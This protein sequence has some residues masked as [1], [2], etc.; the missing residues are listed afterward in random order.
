MSSTF[1]LEEILL[2]LKKTYE[3]ADKNIR[4]QSEQK[5]SELQDEN[6]LLFSSKLLDLLKLSI[7]EIDSNLRLAIILFLKRSIKEKIE[8]KI[9]N[10]NSNEQ[11]IQIYITVLVNPNLSNKEIE[12]L[13]ES[14]M[15]LLNNTTGDVLI[16]IINYINKQISSMPLGSV[17]G[18]ITILTSIIDSSP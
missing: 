7:K 1:N 16:E 8:K 12:N 17:N 9:L 4:Q 13:K 18:I 11:L 10:Q 2:H 5:L 6:I 3:V 15:L 14:F